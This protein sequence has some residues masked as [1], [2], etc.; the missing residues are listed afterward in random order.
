MAEIMEAGKT[1]IITL[2]VGALDVNCYLFFD[3]GSKNTFV[4]DPGGD[5]ALIERAL[6]SNGLKTAYIVNTHAHFDHVSANSELKDATGAPIALHGDDVALLAEAHEHAALWGVK[7]GAQPG[8]DII[9]G[10]GSTL[11][12]GSVTLDVLHTPG[13]T[14]GG[15]CLYYKDAGVLFTG[16]TLFAGSIGRTDLDGG[17][18]DKLLK[19]I[20][21]RLLP[22]DDNIIILPG[23][24]PASTI[25][26]EKEHNPFV[27]NMVL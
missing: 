11:K 18:A 3:R 26:M 15:V 19:S 7:I 5:A 4:I 1:G 12:A 10:D 9:M 6:K 16:D 21:N 20:K 14:P 2:Q 17:S 13:H 27:A 25:G 24:G 8:P 22:L 23:H